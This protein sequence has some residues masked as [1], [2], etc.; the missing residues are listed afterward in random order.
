[1]FSLE[2][3]LLALS[4]L[5]EDPV[6]PAHPTSSAGC[7]PLATPG[8]SLSLCQVVAQLKAFLLFLC[9]FKLTRIQ[10]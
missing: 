10:F 9:Y 8:R 2:A 5:P 4:D 6:A 3:S 1:M 7:E